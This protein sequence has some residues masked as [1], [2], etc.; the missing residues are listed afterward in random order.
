MNRILSLEEFFNPYSKKH[1]TSIQEEAEAARQAPQK[2][3]FKWQNLLWRGW[4]I[5][6]KEVNKYQ[7]KYG[8]R[9][10]LTDR[11]KIDW[12]LKKLKWDKGENTTRVNVL[13]DEWAIHYSTYEVEK[14]I[15][16][17]PEDY[18]WRPLWETEG[19]Q[20]S[21]S[22]C[23]LQTTTN[24][25]TGA[26][27]I[28][29]DNTKKSSEKY[30]RLEEKYFNQ[31]RHEIFLR[32]LRIPAFHNR[33]GGE[34]IFQGEK[35]VSTRYIEEY[36]ENFF[37]LEQLITFNKILKEIQITNFGPTKGPKEVA[38]S[39]TTLYT[40][41]VKARQ[42]VEKLKKEV[43]RLERILPPK[44]SETSYETAEEETN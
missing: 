39:F 37:T 24:P 5:S 27:E 34:V 3:K 36:L 22:L 30:I 43:K 25:E 6:P 7:K 14:V 19:Y 10:L 2:P 29:W 17:E 1:R 23:I 4:N 15:H 13:I 9:F 32:G 8:R 20:G 21:W 12:D 16:K 41:F 35:D 44:S 11:E 42:N 18:Y 33:Y 40:E 31:L 26:E 28:F 38:M